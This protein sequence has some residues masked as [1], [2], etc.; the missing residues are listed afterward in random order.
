MFVLLAVKLDQAT[1]ETGYDWD[2]TMI[3]ALED[4]PPGVPRIMSL[5]TRIQELLGRLAECL[6]RMPWPR[7]ENS[8][9]RRGGGKGG[10]GANPDDVVEAGALVLDVFSSLLEDLP[11]T[12]EGHGYGDLEQVGLWVENGEGGMRS[13]GWGEERLPRE[14]L[15]VLRFF[16]K[17]VDDELTLMLPRGLGEVSAGALGERDE[18]D[19]EEE[20]DLMDDDEDEVFSVAQHHLYASSRTEDDMLMDEEDKDEDYGQEQQQRMQQRQRREKGGRGRGVGV[21]QRRDC[22]LAY[23]IAATGRFSAR[24]LASYSRVALVIDPNNVY[25]HRFVKAVS[26]L[27]LDEPGLDLARLWHDVFFLLADPEEYVTHLAELQRWVSQDPPAVANSA[28][29]E[30]LSRAVSGSNCTEEGVTVGQE[31]RLHHLWRMLQHLGSRQSPR[32]LVEGLAS[33]QDRLWSSFEL[34]G[35][36]ELSWYNRSLETDTRKALFEVSESVRGDNTS[37]KLFLTCLVHSSRHWDSEVRFSASRALPAV[38]S[39]YPNSLSVWEQYRRQGVLSGPGE[40]PGAD[41][42]MGVASLPFNTSSPITPFPIDS[43]QRRLGQL[44]AFGTAGRASD[45]VA[46]LAVL[47]LCRWWGAPAGAPVAGSSSSR[48]AITAAARARAARV[49]QPMVEVVLSSLA[50]GLGYPSTASL[51]QE[52]LLFLMHEWLVVLRLPLGDFPLHLVLMGGR[53]RGAHEMIVAYGEAATAIRKRRKGDGLSENGEGEGEEDEKEGDPF[54]ATTARSRD[55]QEEETENAAARQERLLRAFVRDT[56]PILV[57]LA[58]LAGGGYSLTYRLELLDSLAL[59]A[60]LPSKELLQRQ[61]LMFAIN[62]GEGLQIEACPRK[63]RQQSRQQQQQSVVLRE[64]RVAD[65]LETHMVEL[66]ALELLLLAESSLHNAA[67]AQLADLQ[68]FLCRCLPKAKKEDL[69]SGLGLDVARYPQDVVVAMIDM[70]G[71]EPP[72][73]PPA[74]SNTTSGNSALYTLMP[75]ALGPALQALAERVLYAPRL[76]ATASGEGGGGEVGKEGLQTVDLTVLWSQCNPVELLLHLKVRLAQ[77]T[78]PAHARRLLELTKELL[79]MLGRAGQEPAVLYIGLHLLLWAL[80]RH[81]DTLTLPGLDLLETYLDATLSDTS[82]S[83]SSGGGVGRLGPHMG[84]LV[85]SLFTVLVRLRGQRYQHRD[86]RGKATEQEEEEE[87][88]CGGSLFFLSG[89]ERSASKFSEEEGKAIAAKVVGLLKHLVIE[90]RGLKPYLGELDPLPRLGGGG[91]LGEEDVEH[92]LEEVRKAI[93]RVTVSASGT[94]SA[95]YRHMGAIDEDRHQQLVVHAKRFAATLA[96]STGQGRAGQ[97]TRLVAL[98]ALLTR[99]SP[100]SAITCQ[101]SSQRSPPKDPGPEVRRLLVP[102]LLALCRGGGERGRAATATSENDFNGGGSE[103]NSSSSSLEEMAVRIDAARA[104]GALGTVPPCEL[105]LWMPSSNARTSVLPSP[106]SSSRDNIKSTSRRSSGASS[107]T[108]STPSSLASPCQVRVGKALKILLGMITGSDARAVQLAV[109][110]LRATLLRPVNNSGEE[111]YWSAGSAPVPWEIRPWVETVWTSDGEELGFE[112]QDAGLLRS[113]ARSSSK[114]SSQ[115]AGTVW[116]WQQR[117]AEEAEAAVASSLSS[118]LKRAEAARAASAQQQRS[119]SST[120]WNRGAWD[121]RRWS[122]EQWV[123]QLVWTLIREGIMTRLSA[124][125]AEEAQEDDEMVAVRRFLIQCG[126]ACRSQPALAEALFPLVLLCLLRLEPKSSLIDSLATST[127]FNKGDSMGGRLHQQS[128]IQHSLTRERVNLHLTRCLQWCLP[129]A[130]PRPLQTLIAALVFLRTQSIHEALL[131]SSLSTGSGSKTSRYRGGVASSSAEADPA[132][133]PLRAREAVAAVG[134]MMGLGL[135]KLEVVRAALRCGALTAAALYLELHVEDEQ[136]RHQAQANDHSDGSG[137]ASREK[138]GAGSSSSGRNSNVPTTTKEQTQQHKQEQAALLMNELG[139]VRS[140]LLRI[141]GRLAEPDGAEGVQ[142]GT[143]LEGRTRAAAARESPDWRQAL[144]AHDCLVLQRTQGG[145]GGSTTVMSETGGGSGGNGLLAGPAIALQKLDLGHVLGAYLAG[146]E[147]RA[148]A[149]HEAALR[150]LEFETSWRACRWQKFAM[151]GSISSSG[152]SSPPSALRGPHLFVARHF[153]PSAADSSSLNSPE[154][155]FASATPPSELNDDCSLRAWHREGRAE[156]DLV[157]GPA[158]S[159]LGRQ[160]YHEHVHGGLRAL[161]AQDHAGLAYH[162]RTARLGLLSC[163]AQEVPSEPSRFLSPVLARLQS[164]REIEEVAALQVMAKGGSSSHTMAVNDDVDSAIPAVAGS[165]CLADSNVDLTSTRIGIIRRGE[166][167][168]LI[169]AWHARSRGA[170]EDD[171]ELVEPILAVREILIRALCPP[172]DARQALVRHSRGLASAAR[173]AGNLTIAAS[174]MDR[175]ESL[176]LAPG[177]NTPGALTVDRCAC[178]LEQARILWAKG[179]ADLAIRSAAALGPALEALERSALVIE[180]RTRGI[181]VQARQLAGRWMAAARSEGTQGIIDRHL[182]PAVE[183]AVEGGGTCTQRRRAHLTLANFLTELHQRR[184]ERLKSEEMVRQAELLRQRKTELEATQR[185][186]EGV[187]E[188]DPKRS[189]LRRRIGGLRKELALDEA[190]YKAQVNSL[191]G[192]SLDALKQFRL[193]LCLEGLP[194]GGKG[195]GGAVGERRSSY[196]GHCSACVDDADGEE[197]EKDIGDDNDDDLGPIFR[198]VAL[199]FEPG[200]ADNPAVN[201]EMAKLVTEVPT[202]KLVPLI[203][204]ILSRLGSGTPD[205]SSAIE[206]LV[207]RICRD[208]PHHT[209]LQLY[210]LRHGKRLNS[211]AARDTY[212]CMPHLEEKVQAAQGILDRLMATGNSILEALV[213][214]TERL[215][216]GYIG[217]ASIKRSQEMK[218][219]KSLTFAS[220]TAEP[221]LVR[222]FPDILRRGAVGPVCGTGSGVL[223]AALPAVVSRIPRLDPF[224]RYDVQD[225]DGSSSSHMHVVRVERFESRFINSDSGLSRPMIITCLGTDGRKY[226]QVIKADDVRSDAIMMQVFETMNTLLSRDPRARRRALHIRTYRVLP[227]TPESGVLEF[228]ENTRNLSG[229]LVASNDRA[230]A[231]HERYNGDTDFTSRECRELLKAARTSEERRE[232]YQTITQNFHPAFRFF[233]LE[234]FPDPALWYRKR[235]HYTRSVAVSSIVGYVLGIGDRHASNILVDQATAG[236][237]HIDFGYT[238]EQ[239]KILPQPET[240]PFRLTR[241]VVDAMGV[242]G[243]EGVFRQCCNTTMAVLRQHAPSL[244]TILEVCVHDPLHSWVRAGVPQVLAA[245]EAAGLTTV[246]SGSGVKGGGG[247]D[248]GD[249]EEE[250]DV[251]RRRKAVHKMIGRIDSRKTAAAMEMMRPTS[252]AER[253]LLRIRQKLKGYEDPGG[254]AMG[255]EGHV[256][257]LISEATD[258]DNLCRIFVGWSPWL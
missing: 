136:Q 227:L 240:V 179:E 204:Q 257:Y 168:A 216:E 92:G 121:P 106:A 142:A 57:P 52:H 11:L 51:L 117:E 254:D 21:I 214:N 203:Y 39:V 167:H 67:A 31:I 154:E 193:A 198:V 217:L 72:A 229:L 19:G 242:T 84:A 234:T 163:L 82:G 87:L 233:F 78:S 111:E 116:Q 28:R 115:A 97:V 46:R 6:D 243:T 253:A 249:E 222:S 88:L 75:A 155:I 173:A 61:K 156:E 235:L 135:N 239:G 104:L 56:L 34:V 141:S 62:E 188:K 228:V 10:R 69:E 123:T 53:K 54:E 108:S 81:P 22:A 176:L 124:E 137:G 59:A 79:S 4:F 89:G 20:D 101:L 148:Q 45:K 80:E 256:K 40:G 95:R 70:L 218:D 230:M 130:G 237:V 90:E 224:A 37:R 199:W 202:Y 207:F 119:N 9:R 215:L 55:D 102:A 107:A 118:P 73:P 145:N 125:K 147:T 96:R 151:G 71:P 23:E 171:F 225:G 223:L 139:E 174:V 133:Q 14:A 245:G 258:P 194:G 177:A 41:E 180:P 213:K 120:L 185:E 48:Q 175:V 201:A 49:V 91:C 182:R 134:G 195:G 247:T 246:L 42:A 189:D 197:E 183:R 126:G 149:S 161:A 187:G 255:V 159:L 184:S 103:N 105:V 210:A 208:H 211:A 86:G 29:R 99:L 206:T 94:S 212:N 127:Q 98:K 226:R 25:A 35:R 5:A 128:S 160:R 16:K 191:S 144:A 219:T 3:D 129:R 112:A 150:E 47:V 18:G 50:G 83:S 196:D 252:D 205:F 113:F 38:F 146:L 114:H 186:Y 138:I 2:E 76:P 65:V 221:A 153:P 109:E 170:M 1:V 100:V 250:E 200:N 27:L 15:S 244:L 236:L 192:L 209:L 68:A 122:Y 248:E 152:G 13:A 44:M 164:L 251:G 241:D 64:G 140:L 162:L 190:D 232:A 220:L 63:D 58:C 131:H 93:A 85:V 24:E 181:E 110:T 17:R 231:L 30:S 66:K 77:T 32:W 132:S 169:A 7:L 143:G 36:K 172:L 26:S 8:S 12:F 178:K 238:F 157:G 166:A 33:V 60:G 158:L 43:L 74:S 165:S